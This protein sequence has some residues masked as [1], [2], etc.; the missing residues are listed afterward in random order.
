MSGANRSLK[1]KII[2]KKEKNSPID[3]RN[4]LSNLFHK[5]HRIA[6]LFTPYWSSII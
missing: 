4:D 6:Q 2:A 5:W 1:R 3:Y